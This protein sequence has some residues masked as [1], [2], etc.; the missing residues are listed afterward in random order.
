[1]E[2]KANTDVTIKRGKIYTSSQFNDSSEKSFWGTDEEAYR[3]FAGVASFLIKSGREIIVDLA[4][5]VDDKSVRPY[6]LGSALGI[7]MHQRGLLVLHGSAVSVG[8]HAVAFLGRSGSGK[9]TMA[10]A[11]S[12]RYPLVTDDIAAVKGDMDPPLVYPAFPQIKLCPDAAQSLGYDP[13]RL[14]S[15]SSDED[16]LTAQMENGFSQHPLPLR[17]V[18]ILEDG[19]SNE[20]QEINRQDAMMALVNN[21]YTLRYLKAQVKVSLHFQQCA[22]VVKYVPVRRLI[23]PRDLKALPKIVR[24]LE[25]DLKCGDQI[26]LR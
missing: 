8:G 12:I 5:N 15:I 20:I 25:E 23:R 22:N 10:A 13:S 18:Y 4:S 26:I 9:S 3:S 2:G 14:L 6:I 19:I 21:T 1:M 24:I 17:R 16:K 11:L 7:L